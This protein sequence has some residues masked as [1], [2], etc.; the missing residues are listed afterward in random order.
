MSLIFKTIIKLT[1]RFKMTYIYQHQPPEGA[2]HSKQPK[3][4][5][6]IIIDHIIYYIIYRSSSQNTKYSHEERD[7]P[8]KK[9]CPCSSPTLWAA[10][11]Q[12]TNKQTNNQTNKRLHVAVKFSLSL[13]LHFSSSKLDFNWFSLQRWSQM[14]SGWCKT[15]AERA[16]FRDSRKDR[17]NQLQLF[18]RQVQV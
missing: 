10:A 4:I 15:P 18:L 8:Q 2:I 11:N 1:N 14:T 9:F 16:A 13:F 12:Q 17:T 3:Y 7:S 6:L 5:D